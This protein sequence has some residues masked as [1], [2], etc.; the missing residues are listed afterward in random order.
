MGL[1]QQ[2]EVEELELQRCIFAT[3]GATALVSTLVSRCGMLL[4]SRERK[5]YLC[6]KMLLQFCADLQIPLI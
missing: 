6:I 1:G 5:M 2:Q 4:L 3:N